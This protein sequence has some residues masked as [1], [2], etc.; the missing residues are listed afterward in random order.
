MGWATATAAEAAVTTV[1]DTATA[2]I[3]Y[4]RGAEAEDAN[5]DADTN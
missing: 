5:S 1:T 3:I 2:D 4:Y